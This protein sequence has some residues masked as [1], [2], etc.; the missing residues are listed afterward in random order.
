M[1]LKFYFFNQILSGTGPVNVNASLTNVSVTG[2]GN[3]KI[4]QNKV[5]PRTYDFLTKVQL[6]KLRIDG[7]YI[8]LGRI[9]VIPLRGNGNCWFDASKCNL[10]FVKIRIN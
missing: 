10:S 6:P 2:F 5:N 7:H 9:L 8:L 1:H 3:A 4:L